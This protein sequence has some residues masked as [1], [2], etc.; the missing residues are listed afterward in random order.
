LPQARSWQ[1]VS[2]FLNLFS[3]KAPFAA[4]R[5]QFFNQW[6]QCRPRKI[7][8]AL[9]EATG[10][11]VTVND[12][13]GALRRITGRVK[14]NMSRG[15]DPDFREARAVRIEV[16]AAEAR[17]GM[18]SPGIETDASA[19]EL[20]REIQR[21]EIHNFQGIDS[22]ELQVA[23]GAGEGSWLMLLGENG[24]GKTAALK[25]IALTLMSADERDRVLPDPTPVAAARPR[26]RIGASGPNRCAEHPRAPFRPGR[27]GSPLDR[28]SGSPTHE[29]YGATRLLAWRRG[30]GRQTARHADRQPL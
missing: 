7:E 15:L 8:R 22:I 19:Y 14:R 28:I 9:K 5:R 21:V 6:V 29:C 3:T 13:A 30:K 20:G 26:G 25:A 17:L 23:G 24:A 16:P 1:F 2:A 18:A 27:R 10:G 11:E 4:L 12:S